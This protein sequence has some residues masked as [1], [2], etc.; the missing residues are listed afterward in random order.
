MGLPR[1]FVTDFGNELL[2]DT[3]VTLSESQSHHLKNVLRLKVG[4][5]ICVVFGRQGREARAEILSID[6][7]ITVKLLSQLISKNDQDSH[8]E[9]LIFAL[10]KGDRNEQ[11]I[12]WATQLG[13]AQIFAFQAERSVILLK[14]AQDVEKKLARFRSTAEKS[15]AQ[16]QRTS[17]PRVELFTSLEHTLPSANSLG[18]LVCSLSKNALNLYSHPQLNNVSQVCLAVGPEGDFT[19]HEME[20]FSRF[21]FHE[22]SLG[23]L[24][25]RSELAC[26]A[27]I[28]GVDT[29][30]NSH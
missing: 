4:D 12:D 7:T 5:V 14:S 9:C 26:V 3:A 25:L 29:V 6:G 28:V 30:L 15:A 1:V 18:K 27:A 22:I 8:V 2:P 13:V 23:T 11:I 16:S 24:V 20:M 19:P 17:I 10:C 21:N